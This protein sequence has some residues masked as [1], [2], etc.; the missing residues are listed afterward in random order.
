MKSGSQESLILE[1]YFPPRGSQSRIHPAEMLAYQEDAVPAYQRVVQYDPS[2][3]RPRWPE[4]FGNSEVPAFHPKEY[5]PPSYHETGQKP[6]KSRTS[7][8]YPSSSAADALAN[9]RS[10]VSFT[11]TFVTKN[12]SE[13]STIVASEN[14]NYAG[15]SSG[16]GYYAHA[17][18]TPVRAVAPFHTPDDIPPPDPRPP[19]DERYY[20]YMGAQFAFAEQREYSYRG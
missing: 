5:N 2:S 9:S 19:S 13:R 12:P 10:T 11:P 8:E 6:K 3:P 7:H 1:P 16:R 20:S 4:I 18:G 15:S 17:S 14:H